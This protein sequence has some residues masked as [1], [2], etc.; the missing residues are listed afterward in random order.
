MLIK[1][2]VVVVLGQKMLCFKNIKH[3]FMEHNDSLLYQ[4]RQKKFNL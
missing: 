4:K 1:K 3:N 2:V